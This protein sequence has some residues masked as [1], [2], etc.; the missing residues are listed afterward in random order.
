MAAQDE[1]GLPDAEPRPEYV[2]KAK[3]IMRE[4]PL[5]VGTTEVLRKM[6]GN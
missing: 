4:C 5:Y 2:E 3:A 1:V 6:V